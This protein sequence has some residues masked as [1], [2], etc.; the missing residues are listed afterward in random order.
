M[1]PIE[2]WLFLFIL[3]LS[4]AL[5]LG[6]VNLEIIK[7]ALMEKEPQIGYFLAI[8]TGIGAMTG[9]FIVAF[10]I[11]TL[12]STLFAILL[13]NL[14]LKTILFAFNVILLSYLGFSAFNKK[15]TNGIISE[16]AKDDDS[17]NENSIFRRI[18]KR[19][20]IGFIIVI[21][22]PWSYLW[23]ASFG[24]L[25]VFGDFNSL[26]FFSRL[27]IVI[28]FLSGVLF[29]VIFFPTL[30]TVS[31]KFANEEFLNLITKASASILLIYAGNFLLETL[32]NL[33]LWL[34]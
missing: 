12:G 8:L 26:D 15:I 17:R 24:S 7:M 1:N 18:T 31:K 2:L 14:A 28:C 6:P 27:T 32:Y 34:F 5:P 10:S 22:S 9:D 4:L 3:G 16:E 30:L 11:L 33:H 20:V 25:I 13:N 19:Y 29:W 23:W 21:S